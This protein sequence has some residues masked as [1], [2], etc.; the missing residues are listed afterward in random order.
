MIIRTL[1]IGALWQSN[2]Y[3]HPQRLGA[4]RPPDLRA[5]SPQVQAI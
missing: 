1:W 2:F 4:C 5:L 3:K